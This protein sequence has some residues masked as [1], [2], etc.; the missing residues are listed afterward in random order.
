MLVRTQ[1]LDKLHSVCS[2]RR[3]IYKWIICKILLEILPS[4]TM[5]MKFTAPSAM[6]VFAQVHWYNFSCSAFDLGGN[7]QNS[8]SICSLREASHHLTHPQI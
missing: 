1:Y 4:L 6:R 3:P 8:Y 2:S 7:L 5:M